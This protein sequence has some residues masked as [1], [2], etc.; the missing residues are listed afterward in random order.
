MMK[1]DPFNVVSRN[2]ADLKNVFMALN[3]DA[4]HYYYHTITW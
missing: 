2:A 1:M 4:L 3:E